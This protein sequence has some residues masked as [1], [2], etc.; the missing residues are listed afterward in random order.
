[1][2][3]IKLFHE[4]TMRPLLTTNMEDEGSHER[5]SEEK[6]VDPVDVAMASANI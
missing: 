5:L 6:A 4:T 2:R 3:S 1:M